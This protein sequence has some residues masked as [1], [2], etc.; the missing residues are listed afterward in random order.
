MKKTFLFVTI[1]LIVTAGLAQKP[2]RLKENFDFDWKF[3]LDS[4]RAAM[5]PAYSDNGWEEVQLPHDWSIKLNFDQKAGGSAG[6]L[7]GG[8]GLY[9]K[10]F[11]LPANF[12]GKKV[13]ILFDGVYHQC[14]V[15]INGHRLGFHPYGYI[16]FEYD[17]TRWLNFGGENL[18]AV[19]V[20]HSNSPTSRWYSGSGIYRHVWLQAVNSVHVSTWG[21]YVTTPSV[22]DKKADIKIATTIVNDSDGPRTVTVSQKIFDRSSLQVGAAVEKVATIEA[23]GKSDVEQLLQ[24]VNPELWT[25]E[26]PEIYVMSTTVKTGGQ[27]VDSYNTPFGIRTFS[28]DKDKG[29]SLNGKTIKLKGM[30]LHQDAGSL[31]TAVPDRS[32]ERRLEIL[33]EYGCNAIRCSHNPPSPE[34]LDMCDRMG[35]VVID[36]AFDKWKSGY[37]TK[38]FDEW[39]QRDLGDMLRRDRNHPSVMLWSIGNEVSEAKGGPENVKRAEML[40][41]FVHR[42]EPTRPV[43]LALQNGGAQDFAGV[44]DVIGYNYLETRMLADR[45]KYPERIF[46]ITEALPYFS[47]TDTSMFRTYTPVNPWYV[48]AENDFVAGQ[49]LWVGADYLGEAFWPSKGWA[50]G[51]FDLCMFEKPRAAFHRAVWNSKPVVAIAV[52]DQSLNIDPPRDLWQWPNLAAHWNFP[53][54]SDG[55]MVEVRTTTNCESVE[56]YFGGNSMGRRKT[57]DYTNNTIIWYVPYRPGT[58]E[59]R[60]FNKGK[61][62]A[63]YKLVTSG[64]ADHLL[65]KADRLE[66]K[67]DGQDL[68][69][70]AIQIYDSK[71]N[72]V[73]TD[74]R[75]IT[76][77]LE[78]EGRFLGIDNGETRR[79]VSFS[80]NQLPTYFGKAL[81]IVQSTRR[82]GQLRVKIEMEGSAEPVYLE[83]QSR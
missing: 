43:T 82:A 24:I 60:G 79:D 18:L 52:A 5:L 15:Y 73:Q 11:T 28:F 17:L 77:T 50:S 45:K 69:H 39:W 70:I 47:G 83:L 42:M 72:P 55:R 26:N 19:R 64:N 20:D 48:V 46:V 74:D 40:Q 30:C 33:K 4:S 57:S 54:Y 9:R 16:G 8:I 80:G 31:G 35:F 58:L 78:G 22:S 23:M 66:L 44:P 2:V 37:Y 14:E 56:L 27:V 12:K 41:E 36:E 32:Y 76:V 62:E 61:E 29:F 68:S 10:T 65:A 53:Q 59:A 71:G 81:A 75:K 7:P 1:F 38:Y 25:L 21:T 3:R 51:L 67:A 34:F 49:F 6:F 63:Y 13:S